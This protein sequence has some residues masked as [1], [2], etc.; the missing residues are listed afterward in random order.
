MKYKQL[1]K[2]G[3]YMPAIGLG[4]ISLSGQYES[5]WDENKSIKLIQEAYNHG[6]NFF[7]TADI[8]GDGHNEE[9][10]YKALQSILST[11]RDNVVIATKYGFKSDGLIL[12]LSPEYI[13]LSCER[14]LKR[15]GI[16]LYRPIL[17]T[18]Y[19]YYRS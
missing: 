2:N 15:L 10:L 8:Y 11:K 6:V 9:L 3:P 1:G 13:I 5:E 4:C 14:S 17:F 19:S 16:E 18:P 12:D 7:D